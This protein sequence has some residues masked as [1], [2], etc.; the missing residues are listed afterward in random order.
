MEL[1][2]VEMESRRVSTEHRNV[3][4]KSRN[5]SEKRRK[6]AEELRNVREKPRNLAE[7]LR[8]LAEKRG[9]VSGWLGN[10]SEI[11]IHADE[12]RKNRGELSVRVSTSHRNAPGRLRK[13]GALEVPPD[14][15]G[16]G[17]RGHGPTFEVPPGSQPEPGPIRQSCKGY[18]KGRWSS[19]S[20][21]SVR[22]RRRG[23]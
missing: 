3:S 8:N 17:P 18:L 23:H 1:R 11:Q 4:E 2:S 16:A 20:R 14:S 13:A 22:L 10:A 9:N 19:P 7:E 12:L 21:S 5:V 6:V 15:L